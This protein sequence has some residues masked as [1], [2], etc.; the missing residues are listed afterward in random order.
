M[1]IDLSSAKKETTLEA[2]Q[3]RAARKLLGWS[4]RELAD[5]A[6]LG[7]STVADFERGARQPTGAN[8][9][10]MRRAAME[11]GVQFLPKG[12]VALRRESPPS[13]GGEVQ[14]LKTNT[15][16]ELTPE[17]VLSSAA[18]AGLSSVLVLGWDKNGELYAAGSA[19]DDANTL[20]LV[21]KFKHELLSGGFGE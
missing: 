17:R 10:S 4:Q 13:P 11:G 2:A 5:R 6:G 15:R 9:R 14:V 3:F 12:A 8:L 20:L 19:G 16:C 21:E 7:L 18:E 1:V